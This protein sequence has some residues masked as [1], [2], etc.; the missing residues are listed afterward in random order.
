MKLIL[1]NIGKIER[2]DILLDGITVIVGENDTGKSTIG[3]ALYLYC[4]SLCNLDAEIA[5]DRF[6]SVRRE[7]RS[8]V[9]ELDLLCK[10]E[11]GAKRRR[12]VSSANALIV[13]TSRVLANGEYED[14]NNVIHNHME[15]HCRLYGISIDRIY[16]AGYYAKWVYDV[17]DRLSRVLAPSDDDISCLSVTRGVK[18]YFES[19]IIRIRFNNKADQEISC[20][21]VEYDDGITNHLEFKKT[22]SGD[23]CS[24][25]KRL[26]AVSATPV[27]LDNPRSLDGIST[28]HNIES[29]D[30]I[31]VLLSPTTSR[32]QHL[33]SPLFISNYRERDISGQMTLFEMEYH[34]Q[35]LSEFENSIV[36]II[37]GK[38]EVDTKGKLQYR[39]K[40]IDR[41]IELCN[42]S[43]GVKSFAVLE[44]AIRHGCLTENGTL[45]LDEPEINL[46]PEWQIKYA[47][48]IIRLQKKLKLNVVITTHSPYFME[49]LEYSAK[50]EGLKDKF[51]CYLAEYENGRSRV[52][53][54]DAFPSYAYKKM[55]EPFAKLDAM[56]R[57]IEDCIDEE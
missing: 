51:H 8:S 13:E 52:S 31:K 14:I 35:L 50:I 6:I 17:S 41:N 12:Q 15:R 25:T 46:H 42:L 7:L 48:L 27:Y 18:A 30:L 57:K 38:F 20:I 28:S 16:E 26:K 21:D 24:V 49:A 32:G 22:K 33:V 44:W 55:A 43:S 29:P 53:N 1:Q 56:K 11:S 2:A 45:I 5:E 40:E 39:S 3:R 23:V 47:T 19:Q 54:V 4:K 9:G 10:K 37:G 36:D 34:N